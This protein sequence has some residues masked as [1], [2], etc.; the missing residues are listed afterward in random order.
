MNPL[1]TRLRALLAKVEARTHIPPSPRDM[2]VIAAEIRSL[3]LL[4]A[5][6]RGGPVA[7]QRTA[8]VVKFRR[9]A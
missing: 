1:A 2:Q 8:Q 7:P 4:D 9:G 5:M 3:L 6:E